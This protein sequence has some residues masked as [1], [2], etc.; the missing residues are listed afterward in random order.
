MNASARSRSAFAAFLLAILILGGIGYLSMRSL[1]LSHA[2]S[3][4]VVHTHEV[5]E[6]LDGLLSALKDAETGQRG[7]IITGEASYL[8]PYEAGVAELGW[9]RARLARL[10]ADNP[11]QQMRLARIEPL[12]RGKL[13]EMRETVRLRREGRVREATDLIRTD[14]GRKLFES[15]RLEVAEA[16]Q[17]EERLLA[18]REAADDA[19]RGNELRLM[20]FGYGSGFGILAIAFFALRREIA[21]RAT[22]ERELLENREQLEARVAERT[23][24]LESAY[25]RLAVEIDERRQ[26]ENAQRE[27][28]LLL[29]SVIDGTSDAVYVKDTSG[30]FLLKNAA[31]IRYLGRAGREGASPGAEIAAHASDAGRLAESD[32]EAMRAGE[33]RTFE[34]EVVCSDGAARTYL[35]TKGP[36]LD[37]EGRVTGMFTIARDITERKQ[38]EV[39][40]LHLREQLRQSQKMEAVGLLAGGIA[41]YFNN[42]L[43]VIVGH[44]SLLKDEMG[45]GPRAGQMGE[46]VE[47]AV[48][49]SVLARG[50]LAFSHKQPLNLRRDDVNRMIVDLRRFLVRVIGEDV[51]L[52][53]RP[54]PGPLFAVMDEV[55]MQH[56][57]VNLATNAR[58][59]MDSRG[60]MVVTTAPDEDRRFVR[61]TVSDTGCGMTDDVREK[62]FEPFFT[63]KEVGRGTGLGL[64]VVYGIVTQHGGTIAC[65]SAPGRGTAFTILIPAATGAEEGAPADALVPAAAP[66]GG[67]ETILVAEDDEQVMEVVRLTLE[68]R[69]YTVI[70]AANGREALALHEGNRGGI[71][72]V[73]LDYSMP[74][75][76]GG[77][78]LEAIRRRDPGVK[79]FFLSGYAGEGSAAAGDADF[80]LVAKPVIPRMLLAQVRAAL[81]G[82]Q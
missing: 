74:G 61:I 17:E 59:A 9:R 26:A 18:A 2:T 25:A 52:H 30:R 47:T 75:M 11:N 77:E 64:A 19:N 62:I 69:G 45:D 66:V 56:V 46:I 44:A 78:V 35:S 36:L 54:F 53:I 60:L 37:R 3:R 81:D 82:L 14:E 76:N 13:E 65:E 72:L 22:I 67:C 24:S 42:M 1:A 68:G 31:A 29:Q 15:L 20:F 4:W 23:A 38:G 27:S 8:A 43:Q 50:L 12:L 39:D 41:H 6:S 33:V 51:E 34:E 71:D 32:R 40:R 79:G 5:I 70:C 7:Y 58:D 80:P 28:R 55:Q 21:R 16:R 49:A 63:T 48:N 57:L 73:I 10:T